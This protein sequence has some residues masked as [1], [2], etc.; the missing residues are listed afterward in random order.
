MYLKHRVGAVLL[1]AGIGSRF[2]GEIPKQFLPLKGK[3]V[4]LHTLDT[5]VQTGVFDEI[6]LVCHPAW[7]DTVS[8]E[9]AIATVVQGAGTRQ[10]SA[11]LGL[12]GFVNRP[13]I[14]VMHDAV[15]PL[16]SQE[17]LVNNISSALLHGAVDT[18]IASADTLVY[19]PQ[20]DVIEAIPKRDHYLRGQTPQTFRFDLLL[21]VHVAAR[22]DG[23][24][25]VSD[26]CQLVLRKGHPV[27]VVPGSERNF[28]ITTDLDFNLASVLF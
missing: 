13:D 3:R 17:I 1:M 15:R 26:D 19:A 25:A 8:Q 14:V 23:V 28:K 7:Q 5:F 10:E 11:Y 20:G 16:V 21:E 12:L 22:H 4:Y 9:A 2:G 27:H 6:V 24:E 18:C